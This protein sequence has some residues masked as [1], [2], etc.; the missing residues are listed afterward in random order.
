MLLHKLHF[1]RI[2]FVMVLNLK[3]QESKATSQIVHTGLKENIRHI[4]NNNQHQNK[5]G[6]DGFH[7]VIYNY[8]CLK[9][10]LYCDLGLM[11]LDGAGNTLWSK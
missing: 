10:I 5:P 1:C 6:L 9:Q 8:K 4:N 2:R 7:T 11:L 3:T